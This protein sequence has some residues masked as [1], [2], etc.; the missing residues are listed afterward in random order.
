M[1]TLFRRT[2]HR[3]VPQSATLTEKNGQL[4]A[5]WKSRGKSH[6]APV[7]E[8]ENGTRTV[9]VE[10][11]T[12]YARFRDHTG[13]T[14][15][16][17]TGCR[18]E[19]NA[20]QKLAAWEKEAE[21]VRVGVLDAT[22]LDT[23]RA[24]A[25]PIDSHL[26]AYLQSLVVAE[27]SAVYRANAERAVNRL[28]RELALDALRDLRRDKIEPWF[29]KAITDE[30]GAATRN[31]YRQSIVSFA[32]WLAATKRIR[33]HDLAG[34]PLAD[35]RLDPRRQRRALN[36]DEIGRLLIVAASRPLDDARTARTGKRKGEMSADI[37]P[38]V[39][40]RLLALGRERVLV[41]RT[42][43]YTGL[44]SGELRSLNVS[45]LDLTPGSE[46]VWLEAAN[47]KN[48][49]G[50]TIPLRSTWPRNSASGSRRRTSTLRPGCSP[51]RPG[52]A[53]FSTGT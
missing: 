17:S 21:Q 10:T 12:Y 31:Y 16:R 2:L 49:A 15:D 43:I 8:A 3:P 50:S 11:G 5:R 13:N 32:N 41:Y 19:T 23:A 44:R 47:E 36:A 4:F 48:R 24:A 38:E 52:C 37:R 42:L 34:I 9:T 40:E 22:E 45:R 26:A 30:M 1:G 28:C 20:R 51:S 27:V 39:T 46:C 6:T 7:T 29:V 14:V 18:D 53:A 35:R 33:E 25:D